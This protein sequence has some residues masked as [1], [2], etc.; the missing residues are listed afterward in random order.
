MTPEEQLAALQDQLSQL[1]EIAKQ[2]QLT[3]LQ[4]QHEQIQTEMQK[5]TPMNEFLSGVSEDVGS[6]LGAVTGAIGG[7]L[8]GGALGA[9]Y[10]GPVAGGVLGGATGAYLGKDSYLGA[11]VSAGLGATIGTGAGIAFGAPAG[12]YLGASTGGGAGSYYGR[13]AAQ[14]INEMLGI[15]PRDIPGTIKV[16][17]GET[18]DLSLKQEIAFSGAGE[19]IPFVKPAIT[20][21]W[22]G[23]KQLFSG[24][25]DRIFP[26]YA[27]E[28]V[29][30]DP[31]VKRLGQLVGRETGGYLPSEID[32]VPVP[33]TVN[34]AYRSQLESYQ[35]VISRDPGEAIAAQM[36]GFA[37]ASLG[38][39]GAKSSFTRG[40]NKL[41]KD[42][43]FERYPTMAEAIDDISRPGGLIDAN[44]QGRMTLA[45][46][47]EKGAQG[48]DHI[49][50]NRVITKPENL[51][52]YAPIQ[53]IDPLLEPLEARIVQLRAI[54]ESAP[55]AEA[56]QDALTAFRQNVQSRPIGLKPTD[57]IMMDQ[58]YNAYRRAQEEFLNQ[59]IGKIEQGQ[60][61]KIKGELEAIPY[62]QA[63]LKEQLG[64]TVTKI[65]ALRPGLRIN[66][67]DFIDLNDEYGALMSFT[68]ISNR[69]NNEIG[70]GSPL[71]S[72][73]AQRISQ[74]GGPGA[75]S[76]SVAS[77]GGGLMGT[78]KAGFDYANQFRGEMTP[79]DAQRVYAATA[80]DRI[81]K[82]IQDIVSLAK[83]PAELGARPGAAP[84]ERP[85]AEQM[86]GLPPAWQMGAGALAG[87]SVSAAQAQEETFKPQ[88]PIKVSIN[89][90][91][92]DPK[93]GFQLPRNLSSLDP[94]GVA[95][96]IGVMM[97]P[98]IAEPLLIQ[99]RKVSQGGTKEQQAEFLGL[100]VDRYPDFPIQRGPITG[101]NS[102]FDMGD[103]QMR[104]F[105]F[106]DKMKWEDQ[107][108][109]SPL[110]VDE[111]AQRV[112]AL[113]KNGLVVPMDQ[114][115][116][117]PPN[118][119]PEP[120]DRAMD[121]L[122][123]TYQ[124]APRQMTGHG[125]RR[126]E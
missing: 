1:Q 123:Q 30:Q 16:N 14:G 111:K 87:P 55:Q 74:R 90:L 35:T 92:P 10:G 121:Y 57:M 83:N 110:E 75:F 13:Q 31:Q 79:E 19:L 38:T 107:I 93:Q 25:G 86:A 15:A 42:G 18:P 115:L 43:F 2:K 88:D 64:N 95:N 54:P 22:Q 49:E 99:W 52:G 58:Q 113:R 78:I 7:G 76:A 8:G 109:N 41:T 117:L 70:R 106:N 69:L 17:N 46:T 60:A 40:V 12:A 24:L 98:Q 124:F 21:G 89:P 84:F 33:D 28:A 114:K 67:Q 108:N 62:F 122:M 102:E 125:S 126:V 66:A 37:D 26:K 56:L 9:S 44:N 11:P 6:V 36:G 118:I 53:Q 63:A 45:Q 23:A 5:V 103:G 96:M 50:G 119:T 4:S 20:E 34:K 27:D 59:N 105:S 120:E 68:N 85:F 82:N 39:I 81:W 32:N 77:R 112:M 61:T 72:T 101:L 51:K 104:L 97:P 100:L 73:G 94:Q 80:P 71:A 65:S 91:L 47:I 48:L 29:L 116:T 3:D